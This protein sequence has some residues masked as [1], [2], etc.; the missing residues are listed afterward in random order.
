M[1]Q[2]SCRFAFLLTV[3]LSLAFFETQCII[4]FFVSIYYFY[5]IYN[6]YYVLCSVEC[7]L[8]DGAQALHGTNI[9]LK[10]TKTSDVYKQL[11]QIQ[12]PRVQQHTKLTRPSCV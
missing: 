8:S 2:F 1:F 4:T 6:Y 3:R 7:Q 11:T 10:M 5:Y 12:Q 9:A